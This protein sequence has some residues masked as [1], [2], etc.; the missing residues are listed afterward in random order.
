MRFSFNVSIQGCF[1]H[2]SEPRA[3]FSDETRGDAL[4]FKGAVKCVP[5][6][7]IE[8]EILHLLFYRSQE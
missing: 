6:H 2:G 4:L 5:P 3:G 1:S 7:E 8:A